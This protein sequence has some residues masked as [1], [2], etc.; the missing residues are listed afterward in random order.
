[1]TADFFT[2]DVTEIKE[3][4]NTITSQKLLINVLK[5]KID[6]LEK[7]IEWQQKETHRLNRYVSELNET[8]D[9]LVKATKRG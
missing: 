2:Q 4:Q 7:S 6:E 5:Q 1:M 9:S 8:L 3:L